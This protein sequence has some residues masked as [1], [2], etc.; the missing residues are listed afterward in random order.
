MA[1]LD[2][3]ELDRALAGLMG[4]RAAVPDPQNPN[5]YLLLSANVPIP[6]PDDLPYSAQMYHVPAFSQGE[7]VWQLLDFMRADARRWD[8]FTR[9]IERET[10]TVSTLLMRLEP[11]VIAE[12]AYI[13]L[14]GLANEEAGERESTTETR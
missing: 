1:N 12:A 10:P 6:A 9:A 2:P 3:C 7:E 13:A 8:A 4:W 14:R 11:R 5:K